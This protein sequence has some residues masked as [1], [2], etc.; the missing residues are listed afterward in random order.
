MVVNTSIYTTRR[1][2]V[3]KTASVLLFLVYCSI[4]ASLTKRRDMVVRVLIIAD[5]P[6]KTLKFHLS[7]K[8]INV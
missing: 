6:F 4:D 8:Y 1:T 3:C 2:P 7:K 5:F